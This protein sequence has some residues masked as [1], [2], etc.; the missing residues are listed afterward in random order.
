VINDPRAQGGKRHD[1]DWVLDQLLIIAIK[2]Q[3]QKAL[4]VAAPFADRIAKLAKK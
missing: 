1:D 3:N 2:S 4:R